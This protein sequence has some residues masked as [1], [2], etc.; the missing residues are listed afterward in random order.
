[1]VRPT[2]EIVYPGDRRPACT[3]RIDSRWF[4]GEIALWR[5][6]STG[7]CAVVCY[8]VTPETAYMRTV[9]A[10]DVVRLAAGDHEA[11]GPPSEEVAARALPTVGGAQV[12][13]GPDEVRAG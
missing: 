5:L 2:T 12:R 9:P 4:V 13:T 10:E 6:Q 8:F 7:W 1:M 11:S 3:V